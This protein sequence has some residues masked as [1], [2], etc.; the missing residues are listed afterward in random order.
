MRALMR[1]AWTDARE[2]PPHVASS[3]HPALERQQ[4]GA[5]NR[6]ENKACSTRSVGAERQ[7]GS[8]GRGGPWAT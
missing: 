7:G 8:E 2:G 3:N 6:D 4:K 1:I 5:L